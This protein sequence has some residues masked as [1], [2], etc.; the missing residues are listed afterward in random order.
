MA[1]NGGVNLPNLDG[2]F[3][4]LGYNIVG[5][6]GTEMGNPTITSTTGDQ[7]G[8]S[9]A[10]VN[11]G[12][13]QN[14]GGPT[15]TRALLTGSIAIDKG[16][17]SGSTTDQRGL[18]RP[19]NDAA[20]ADA[21]GGDGG[22]VGAFEAQPACSNT[23]PDAVDDPA[24]VAEDSGANSI[25][26]LANDTDAN[27]DTLTITA[28]TQGA[29]GSVAL[30]GGGTGLTYT[31]GANFFGGDSFT[32]TIGDGNS[33]IDTA[34]VTV[35]VTNVQDAPNAVDDT[36][37]VAEDSAG[38]NLAVLGND[39]DV[40]LDALSISAVTQGGHGSVSTN[41]STVSYTPAT[42]FFG[43][44]SFT[45]TISDG[46]GG[47]DTATVNVTVTNVNDP[48]VASANNYSMNQDTTLTIAAPGVLGNDSDIDGDTLNAQ[49]VA[50][51]SHGMVMLAS[52]GSFTY[53]PNLSF[54][55]T[56]SF[57]YKAN[58][59]VADSNTVLVTIVIADT[60][61]P[62]ITAGLATAVLWPPNHEL[63]DV[64]LT[65]ST[66]DNSSAVTTQLTV[67]SD[68]DDLMRGSGNHSPDSKYA[69]PATLR[70]RA[71]RSGNDDG[72]IYLVLI[73]A[74]DAAANTSR[75]CLTAIVPKSQSAS[76]IQSV[77]DRAQ[78]VAAL[79]Q[80]TGLPPAGFLVV[81]D[82]PVVGPKQ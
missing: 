71:E 57:T 6:L 46:Q 40:D 78:A 18:T 63:V 66:T 56:D 26:V 4:S 28:L 39:S 80:A 19:C 53:A 69:A 24:T 77:I 29:H 60:Q 12:P 8:V 45:Y 58:D 62:A 72:R 20:I 35:N 34:T 81:G 36:A 11:V 38:N 15:P 17:S 42:N 25:D 43:S 73:T 54:A 30:A 55:G 3:T 65:L 59:G 13:L 16:H 14:N 23:P 76:K 79:C 7:I 9:D 32:Y 49:L 48:P 1:G 27:G 47:S 2:T 37:T 33:G 21:T 31:P 67:Y 70:L 52:N 51:V 75:R 82:G 22:D 64:G 10:L 68:E 50:N 41:G 44:D 5:N 61:P 74:R